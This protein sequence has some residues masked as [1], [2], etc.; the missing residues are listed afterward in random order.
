MSHL[1]RVECKEGMVA[2]GKPFDVLVPDG[3]GNQYVIRGH[4]SSSGAPRT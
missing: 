3:E 1:L 4:Q 2:T